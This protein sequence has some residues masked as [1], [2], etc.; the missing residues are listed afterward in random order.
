MKKIPFIP[1]KKNWIFIDNFQR[2][3]SIKNDSIIKKIIEIFWKFVLLL[4]QLRT[5]NDALL[6]K[7]VFSFLNQ[8][9]SFCSIIHDFF[10]LW[11]S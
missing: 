3:I 6:Q 9:W 7:T 10:V 1:T 11:G 2:I 4:K 5:M 8:Q